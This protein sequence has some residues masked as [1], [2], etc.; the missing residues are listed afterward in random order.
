MENIER[1]AQLS[2]LRAL[3]FAA[4][5]I[6]TAMMGL[7]Y[8][9]VLCFFWG[10]GLCLITAVIL[11]WKGVNAPTRSLRKTEIYI[12]LDKDFG[13]PMEIAQ[14]KIGQLL[15]QIYFR[16]AQFALGFAIL[17]WSVSLVLR[18]L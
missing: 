1:L 10:A 11:F 18:L 17:F 2:I 7:S 12:L 4:L 3:G 9:P 16:Y 8:E 13:M 5:G 15:R 6:A 14:R